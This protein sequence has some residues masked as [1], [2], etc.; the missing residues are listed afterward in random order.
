MATKHD[1]IFGPRIVEDHGVYTLIEF[2]KFPLQGLR[3]SKPTCS[4]RVI[5]TIDGEI[6]FWVAD[7]SLFQDSGRLR[8][9][10]AEWIM[11]TQI[12]FEVPP[13]LNR[14]ESR[15][16]RYQRLLWHIYRVL[17]ELGSESPK[18]GLNS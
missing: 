6:A 17:G 12:F 13:E 7:L 16:G 1:R 3:Y 15:P 9:I 4:V 2:P 8:A 14:L 18:G 5:E 10:P 11:D